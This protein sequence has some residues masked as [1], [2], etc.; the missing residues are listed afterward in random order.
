MKRERER[1]SSLISRILGYSA[2]VILMRAMVVLFAQIIIEWNVLK[3]KGIKFMGNICT[4]S[5]M[6]WFIKYQVSIL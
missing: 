4:E 6:F 5:H 2:Y 1:N 3:C